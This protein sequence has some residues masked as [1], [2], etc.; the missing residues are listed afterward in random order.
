MGVFESLVEDPVDEDTREFV[1][2]IIMEA[3][4][5]QFDVDGAVL[6]DN[7]FVVLDAIYTTIDNLIATPPT[8]TKIRPKSNT[9][10]HTKV[11]T[12]TTRTQPKDRQV[13]VIWNNNTNKRKRKKKKKKKKTP[14]KKKKKK[15]KKKS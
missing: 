15:K 10:T 8:N 9:N 13:P 7:L 5:S 11:K 4:S 12:K 1:R 3:L 2:A 6:C 14:P